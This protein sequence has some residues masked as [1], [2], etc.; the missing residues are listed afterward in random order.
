MKT[1]KAAGRL[2]VSL[3]AAALLAASL[4][5]GAPPKRWAYSALGD[6]L[7]VGALALQGYVPRYQDYIQTDTHARVSLRNLAQNGWTSQDLLLALQSDES[8][9]DSVRTSQVVTWDIGGNDLRHARGSYKAGTCYEGTLDNEHCLART[10]AEFKMNWDLIVDLILGLRLPS[11]TIIR[12]MDL[13]NP[14]VKEDLAVDTDGDGR[15][16]FQTLKQYHD[17]VNEHIHANSGGIPWAAVA[18]A[19][20]GPNGDQDPRDKGY[21]AFDGVHP[22]DTGHKVIADR[23]RALGYAP[24]GK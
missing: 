21:I 9:R 10:L 15:S 8:F 20:N 13:Y 11:N 5:Y 7:A 18:E 12:T 22:N 24:L 17:W 6:S 19:F 3:G 1:M 23:L 4:S 16:D 14:F 2:L